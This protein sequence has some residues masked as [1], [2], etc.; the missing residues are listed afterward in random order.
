MRV[1]RSSVSVMFAIPGAV[2]RF[3][4]SLSE[5]ARAWFTATNNALFFLLFSGVWLILL[6]LFYNRFAETIKAL[7]DDERGTKQ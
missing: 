3:R 4:E 2:D 6:G 5:R 7:L 1:L